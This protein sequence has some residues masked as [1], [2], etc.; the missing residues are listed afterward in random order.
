[1]TLETVGPS[2]LERNG[3]VLSSRLEHAEEIRAEK[4][5]RE[6]IYTAYV[7]RHGRLDCQAALAEAEAERR[8]A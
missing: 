5:R 2:L 1:M 7:E 8:A 6:A 3:V 4:A